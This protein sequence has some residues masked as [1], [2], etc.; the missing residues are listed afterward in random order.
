MKTRKVIALI[1]AVIALVLGAVASF[2]SQERKAEAW[3][4]AKVFVACLPAKNTPLAA[5]SLIATV[6]PDGIKNVIEQ[7]K[8]QVGDWLTYE[9]VGQLI[10][11]VG[12]TPATLQSAAQC[13]MDR[14]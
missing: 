11:L 5:P 13:A 6:F 7:G 3:Q 8:A 14:T 10:E 12:H 9:Q 4:Q 2:Q 1:A